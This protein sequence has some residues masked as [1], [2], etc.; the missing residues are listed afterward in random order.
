M[1]EETEKN[2]V[3]A[4]ESILRDLEKLKRDVVRLEKMVRGQN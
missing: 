1:T 3:E 4:V 2:L